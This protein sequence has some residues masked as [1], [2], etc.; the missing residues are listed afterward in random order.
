[1]AK[2]KVVLGDNFTFTQPIT[3]T[4][5]GDLLQANLTAMDT[6]DADADCLKVG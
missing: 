6:L 3:A 2:Y 4:S 5:D 1:M